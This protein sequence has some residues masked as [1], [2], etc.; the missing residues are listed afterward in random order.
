MRDSESKIQSD[1]VRW[2]TNTYCLAHHSPRCIIWHTPNENQHKHTNLGV[3]GGVPDLCLI[4]MG[5]LIFIEMKDE[6]GKLRP[7]QLDFKKRV[8]AHGFKWFLCRSLE[9][10]KEIIKKLDKSQV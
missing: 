4:H 1:C 8:E 7:A 6:K 9:S 2:Y 5:Q 10:F 3:L